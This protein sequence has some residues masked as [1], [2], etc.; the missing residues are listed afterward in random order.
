MAPFLFDD[1]GYMRSGGKSKLADYL[2]PASAK[3]RKNDS[4][5]KNTDTKIVLDGG[6]LIQRVC[7][8]K[9]STFAQI[10]RDYE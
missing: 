8:A 6:A 4:L 3:N 7:W 10:I 5:L 2:V 9:G 1:H